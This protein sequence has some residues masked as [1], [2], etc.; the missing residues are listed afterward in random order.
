[1]LLTQVAQDLVTTKLPRDLQ[2]LGIRIMRADDPNAQLRLEICL[3]SIERWSG[4]KERKRALIRAL[5]LSNTECLE[6][7]TVLPSLSRI[8]T[9]TAT[10]PVTIT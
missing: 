6:R 2:V 5:V 1:M 4:R 10:K 7:D 3:G 9:T 8:T